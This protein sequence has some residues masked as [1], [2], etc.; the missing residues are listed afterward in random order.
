MHPISPSL[1]QVAQGL[2][3]PSGRSQ[4]SAFH[5]CHFIRVA[6]S[7]RTANRMHGFLHS[8]QI[9]T[10]SAWLSVAGF[11]TV[12]VILKPWH[13]FPPSAQPDTF[14]TKI[15]PSDFIM[16]AP[17]DL[18]D[19]IPGDPQAAV[20]PVNPSTAAASD[21]P[22]PPELAPL[23]EMSP[24]PEV[25]DLPPPSPPIPAPAAAPSAAPSQQSPPSAAPSSARPSSSSRRSSSNRSSTSGS[26]T[27]TAGGTGTGTSLASRLSAGRMPAPTYPASAKRAGQ[28]G[29][30]MVE[31]TIGTDGRV[32]SAHAKSPCPWPS[33]NEAAVRAVR[34]WKFPPGGVMTTQRRIDFVLN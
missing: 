4:S 25:P 11:G 16:Q 7:Y 24:L 14:E 32:L 18:S 13:A 22:L 29:S 28:T 23:E 34:R 15:I 30:V 21:L 20:E 19:P 6:S 33:L 3:P 27:G 2:G 26:A 10:L 9:G 5:D 12:G 31:F 8:L 17:G 1:F